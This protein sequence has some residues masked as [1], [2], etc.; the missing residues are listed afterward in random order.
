MDLPSLLPH[1]RAIARTAGEQ[2]MAVYQ[3]GDWA[4]SHKA[5]ASPLTAADM[6]SHHHIVQQL[7]ALTPSY[8]VLSEENAGEMAAVERR[9]WQTYWLV[10]PLDGT[11][12]FLQRNGEFS[13]LIALVHQHRPVLGVVHA[14]ALG[15]S[16]FAYQGG[17]AFKQQGDKIVPIRA[18]P[19]SIPLQVVGSKSHRDARLPAF[20]QRLGTHTY[21][22]LGSILKA[23]RVAEGQADLYPRFGPTSEWDTAA[24]QI[25]VEEAGGHVTD[26]AMQPLRYNTK[27]SLLNPSFFVFGA[28]WHDWGQ[29]LR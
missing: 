26:T 5:D 6:A 17:G 24:A 18:R 11:R 25:I 12:E 8:P 3:S 28:T 7:Q 27:D 22:A 21:Q 19:A 15:E 20:L 2:V 9:T 16:W 29:Y 4:V 23:C 10:D 13:I 1:V 14:P